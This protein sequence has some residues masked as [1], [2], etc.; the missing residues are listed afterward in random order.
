MT[1]VIVDWAALGQTVIAA[2]VA[3]VGV[4]F[5]FSLAIYGVA[6]VAE[7]S[8]EPGAGRPV[9]FVLV[10]IAGFVLTAAVITFG[11]VVMI[12]G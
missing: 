5:T 4:A 7:G 1:A 8:R 9:L 3:G 2:I 6:R 10:A 12:R 11:I